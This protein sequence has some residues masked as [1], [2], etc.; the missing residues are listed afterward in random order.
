MQTKDGTEIYLKIEIYILI[1]ISWGTT[2]YKFSN[3]YHDGW[4]YFS[5]LKVSKDI[6][7][8]FRGLF[9]IPGSSRRQIVKWKTCV[10]N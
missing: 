6:H 8:L 10:G 3:K 4:G 5:Y 1:K 7:S 9:C 2:F